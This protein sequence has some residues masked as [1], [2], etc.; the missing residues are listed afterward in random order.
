MAEH[1]RSQFLALSVV[2]LSLAVFAGCRA[3]GAMVS[4]VETSKST[5]STSI[6]KKTFSGV[7]A[8]HFSKA[9][10]AAGVTAQSSEDG[11]DRVAADTLTCHDDHTTTGPVEC[12]VVVADK[13]LPLTGD[14]ASLIFSALKMADSSPSHSVS[15]KDVVCT[16][17]LKP[18]P[19]T[20]CSFTR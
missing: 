18:V 5:Q 4:S 14:D 7:E 17:G 13:A 20:T 2:I 11:T 6:T 1:S 10:K 8:V 15:A 12:V 19:K 3:S 9:L 16:A